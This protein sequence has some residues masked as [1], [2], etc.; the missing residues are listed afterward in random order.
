MMFIDT[1]THLNSEKFV[2]DL[3]DVI[4]NAHNNGV[5]KMVVVGYDHIGNKKAVEIAEKYENIYAVVGIH[6]LDVANA[7]DQ[8]K[9]FIINSLQN[10][11]VI[12]LGE[13]GL[14]YYYSKD[15]IEIQKEWFKWH[16]DMSIKFEKPV[17]IHSRDAIQETYDIMSKYDNLKAVL[18]CFSGTPEMAK[19]FQSLGIYISLAGPLTFKNANTLK[20]VAKTA[21]LD[22]L[23]AETDCPYL[24]PVPNRGKR[25]EPANVKYIIAEI[26][27]LRDEE[28]SEVEKKIYENSVRFFGIDR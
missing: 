24:A 11:K 18:H 3:E 16:L 25:N 5:S 14:D 10:S 8:H 20:E 17:V 19:R 28:I 12:G 2:E 15:Y 21:D 22:L 7:T 27:N 6:P 4:K 23:F 26:A 9:E 13:T 1:H